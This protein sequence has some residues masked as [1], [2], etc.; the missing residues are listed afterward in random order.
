M[1]FNSGF[2]EL[3]ATYLLKTGRHT[4]FRALLNYTSEIVGTN[5]ESYEA[6][7]WKE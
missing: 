2:K 6:L 4:N 5:T 3:K 1:G 7:T